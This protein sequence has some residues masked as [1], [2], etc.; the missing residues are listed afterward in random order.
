MHRPSTKVNSG[1]QWRRQERRQG[2]FTALWRAGAA[3]QTGVAAPGKKTILVVGTYD[4]K[5]DELAYLASCI[6]RAG[7]AVVSMDVS[8]LGDPP[9]PTSDHQS[10]RSP[11]RRGRRIATAIARRRR[12]QGDADHGATAPARI[13]K[14]LQADGSSTA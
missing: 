12:E 10:I 5:A 11:R 14:E 13:V 9:A 4:T 8:V 6:E 3:D 7:R 2:E 1:Q